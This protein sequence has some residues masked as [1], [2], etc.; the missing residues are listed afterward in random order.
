M[1]VST[2]V[3]DNGS[4]TIRAGIGGE[5][6]PQTIIPTII[7]RQSKGLLPGSKDVYV[8][9]EVYNQQEITFKSPYENG[10]ISNFEDM[11][12]IWLH[13]FE[14]ELNINMEEHPILLTESIF[15]SKTARETA[16]QIMMESFRVPAYYTTSP[17]LLSLY[18]TGR[19]TGVSVDCGESVTSVLPI[20]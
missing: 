7:G 20:F 11:E 3:V 13:I 2:V 4:Y 18:A 12:R 8:G 15:N 6:E 16:I 1:E 17:S 19:T 10:V 9:S 5:S 14:N